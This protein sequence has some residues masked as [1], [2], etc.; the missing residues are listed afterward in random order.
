MD[1]TFIS[2]HQAKIEISSGDRLNPKID[3]T[4]T[5]D[6]AKCGNSIGYSLKQSYQ[7]RRC[8]IQFV[9]FMTWDESHTQRMTYAN[10]SS[11][12]NNTWRDYISNSSSIQFQTSNSK[13]NFSTLAKTQNQPAAVIADDPRAS[14][15]R[16]AFDWWYSGVMLKNRSINIAARPYP[17]PPI[18]RRTPA[19]FIFFGGGV[20][21][22]GY[23]KRI[24]VSAI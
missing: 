16:T 9:G 17:P 19:F 15:S 22:V 10:D 23:G 24:T 6:T 18:N 3:D 21:K 7:G 14:V 11:T 8:N 20:S 12:L 1:L 2:I 5:D 4:H 13:Q